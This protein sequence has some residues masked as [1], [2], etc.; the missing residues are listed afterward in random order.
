MKLSTL[1]AQYL[2]QHKRLDLA[3]IGSFLLDP[4]VDT[5]PEHYR[6]GKTGIVEGIRF[7]N[8]PSIRESPELVAFIASHSGKIRALAAADLD[9]HLELAR[10]FL[11]IGKPFLFEGIGSLAKLQGGNFSFTPGTLITEKFRE[12]PARET[13]AEQTAEEPMGDYKSIFYNRKL[14]KS[15][16]RPLAVFL[17]LAGF[18]LAV[19]GGYIV[20]K[21]TR[22]SAKS[23]PVKKEVP[24]ETTVIDDTLHKQKDSLAHTIAVQPV[25]PAAGQYKFIVE[26]ADSIRGPKRYATLK[27]YGL[28]VQME[29][30]DSVQFRLFFLL[31]AAAADTVRLLD[32]LRRLY[33]PAGAKAYIEN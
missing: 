14:K 20:Y 32:S 17:I 31:P 6:Q 12:A 2:Y 11:N 8:N 29:T 22:P 27:G 15:P 3:G 26:T 33:T 16:R 13:Q 5:D 30:R 1:L 23:A 7:E 24:A 28:P 21:K 19:W 9:S 18:A 25:I 10:Q 4:S